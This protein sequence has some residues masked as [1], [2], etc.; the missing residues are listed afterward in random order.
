ML[1]VARLASSRVRSTVYGLATID[2]NGRVAETTVINALGWVPGTRLDIRESAGLVLVAASPQGVFSTTG[3]GH[4]RLPATVRHWCGLVAGDRVLLAAEPAQ[5][6]L[7]VHPPTALDDMIS[8]FH[9]TVLGG[10]TVLR[11]DNAGYGK[12]VGVGW[13]E[14]RLSCWMDLVNP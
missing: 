3:Q 6:R 12:T 11:G 14:P 4:L 1:P 8:Q 10:E 9:A 2:C 5:A 13:C 7:V